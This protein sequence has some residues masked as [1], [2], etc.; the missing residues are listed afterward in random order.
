MEVSL[1]I[2]VQVIYRLCCQEI[3]LLRSTCVR[4]WSTAKT[5]TYLFIA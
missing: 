5:E 2:V 1:I 4:T 3:F